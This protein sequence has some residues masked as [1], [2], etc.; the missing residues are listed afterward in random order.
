MNPVVAVVATLSV[1]AA[2]SVVVWQAF[3]PGSSLAQVT[4]SNA[5]RAPAGLAVAEPGSA[6]EGSGQVGLSDAE[7]QDLGRVAEQNGM[8]LQD[9]IDR[10]AWNDDF[11]EMVTQI[12]AVAPESFAGA[13][14][15]DA[16]NAWVAF[17]GDVPAVALPLVEAFSAQYPNV[18]VSM[19]TG[20]GVSELDL[21]AAIES[22]H[23]A[24]LGQDGVL[25][26]TT[27]FDDDARR[28]TI[29]VALERGVPPEA[30]DAL[31]AVATRAVAEA[32]V[33][34]VLDTI[35]LSVVRSDTPEVGGADA[36]N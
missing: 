22:A 1:V 24:V 18:S 16:R 12:R 29:L 13:E 32:G 5:E 10:Y 4:G 9:A 34:H 25:D 27:S 36:D 8:S 31:R 11:A 30:L 15:V 14:I 2:S 17:T 33:G 20:S 26:A 19:R 6:T 3:A 21:E 28:I 7:L 23:Y 35:Q